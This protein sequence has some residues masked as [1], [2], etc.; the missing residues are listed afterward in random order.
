MQASL[1]SLKRKLE[2]EIE[3]ILYTACSF[4]YDNFYF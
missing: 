2:V 3:V 1:L 4:L